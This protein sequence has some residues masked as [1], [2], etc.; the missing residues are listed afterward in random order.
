MSRASASAARLVVLA[1]GFVIALG[2]GAWLVFGALF[3]EPEH[4]AARRAAVLAKVDAGAD[5]PE[6]AHPAAQ[7]VKVASVRGLAERGRAG[8]WFAAQSGDGLDRDEM[9]RTG[10]DGRVELLV[11][12]DRSRITIS[13]RTQVTVAEVTAAVHR[14]Q[15][16]RGRLAVDYQNA[17]GRTLKI[18]SGNGSVAT[19]R[20][21]RFT[22]LSSGVT[23]AVATERGAVTLSAAGGAVEVDAGFQA[24]VTDAETPP[25]APVPIPIEVLL[26]VAHQARRGE[27]ARLSGAVRPGSELLMDGKEIEVNSDGTFEVRVPEVAGRKQVKLVA[28]EPS[29]RERTQLVVCAAKDGEPSHVEI[30]WTGTTGGGR[31]R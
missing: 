18:E 8:A 29:G 11:G 12:D 30:D 19:T 6:P 13:E 5:S 3:I 1:G 9:V 14:F 10:P 20:G 22:V 26:K 28:R 24:V 4:P 21:A 2:V 15:L 17:A 31:A 23:V 27:S 16:S 7:E 25:A